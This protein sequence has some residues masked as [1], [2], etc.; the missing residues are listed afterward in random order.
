MIVQLLLAFFRVGLKLLTH[1]HVEGVENV[2]EPPYLLVTNHLGR[3]DVPFIYATVGGPHLV[4]WAA[5]KY[6]RHLFFG[7]ILRAGGVVF[8]QRGQVDRR[9]LD[10]AVRTLRSGKSFGMA[11]EGTR[12]PNRALIRAKTGAAYL[13]EEADVPIVPVALT[14]TEKAVESWKR[15]RR[16]V[17]TARFGQP[18]RLPKLPKD[19]RT[20]GMRVNTD[21]IMCRIAAMLPPEYRGVY[22]DNPRTIELL[23]A[24]GANA[25]PGRAVPA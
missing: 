13:A 25:H 18:F 21:E 12:S 8:I 16:P 15:L 2:P 3:L 14:G 9:A 6:E 24:N 5:E 1:T 7:P 4:G 22:G 23:G 19:D 11:P 17:M 20:R 10:F